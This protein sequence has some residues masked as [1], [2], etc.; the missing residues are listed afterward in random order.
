MRKFISKNPATKE[1]V[2]EFNFLSDEELKQLILQSQQGYEINRNSSYQLKAK[3][4]LKLS[5][6]LNENQEKYA[7]LISQEVGKPICQSR[8]EIKKSANYCKYYAENI[9]KYSQPQIVITEAKS[10]YVQY[11]PIGTIYSISPFNF[12]FWLCFKPIIPML[13]VGNAVIHRPS[14]STGLCGMALQELFILAGFNENIFQNAFTTAQQLEQVMAHPQIQGVSFTGSTAAGSIIGATAG[15]H[16][17]RSVLELGGSDPFCVLQNANVELA[18]QLALKSRIANCG[19][20]CFSAKRFIVH[21]QYY[22]IFKEK[23]VNALEKLKIGDPLLETTELGPIA[24]EDLI[25]SLLHQIKMGVDQGAKIVYGGTRLK[26]NENFMLPTV[27]EV[28]EKN[29]LV[30]EETFGPLFALIKANSNDE[31]LRIANNTSY[32]LGAVVVSNDKQEIEQFVNHLEA[33]MVFV[34][35]IVKS[36][37][38]LP[39][40]GI[41]GSGYGREC[42]E[43]GVQN[44]ANIK[45]VWIE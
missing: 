35:E 16:L 18:V 31:I 39:S 26:E 43:W 32:G 17:K 20:V 41:K 45:T 38:R 14:D 21:F 8:A 6:L 44:F 28:D 2:Q 42:G 1:V 37:Q 9:D 29:I 27:V 7:R 12:P 30:K 24:R 11:S 3:K 15:K 33:G 10:S 22:D 13:V 34:N 23:L 4:L 40:G 25:T 36:D 5:D 19:Q